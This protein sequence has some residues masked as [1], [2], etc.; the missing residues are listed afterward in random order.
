VILLSPSG[1]LHLEGLVL[2]PSARTWSPAPVPAGS[3]PVGLREAARAAA[4]ARRPLPPVAL[5]GPRTATPAQAEAAEAVGAGLAAM[6]LPVLTGGRGGAMEAACRG[7]AR[8]GG[9]AVGL[10]DSADPADA[11]PWAGVV[12]ATGLGSARNAVIAR[13]A[14]VVVAVGGG[15]GTLSEIAF[16]L[17]AGKPVVTLCGAPE[18]PGVVRAADADAA[19]DAVA[20][21]VL[22]LPPA[23]PAALP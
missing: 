12:L 15:L 6:G 22:A 3:A 20:R 1:T 21:R 16:A 17:H 11:N 23:P 7:A 19:L 5:V 10:L 2:D 18:P 14:D 4:A 8:A 9:V 13:A